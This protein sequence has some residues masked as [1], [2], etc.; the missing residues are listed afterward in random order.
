MAGV[1]SAHEL[2]RKRPEARNKRF[3][4]AHEACGAVESSWRACR[5]V[6][7]SMN[8]RAGRGVSRRGIGGIV[9]TLQTRSHAADPVVWPSVAPGLTQ[10]GFAQRPFTEM[11]MRRPRDWHGSTVTEHPD[12][13]GPMGATTRYRERRRLRHPPRAPRGMGV[14]S[15]ARSFAGARTQSLDVIRP[16]RRR[17]GVAAASLARGSTGGCFVRTDFRTPC[18]AWSDFRH[19]AD[20]QQP[21]LRA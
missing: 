11:R 4:D 18:G 10:R 14:I 12:G 15:L 1:F 8:R 19:V 20:R 2:H 3:G 7:G 17:G 21:C 16:S 9:A 13:D 5:G 6:A